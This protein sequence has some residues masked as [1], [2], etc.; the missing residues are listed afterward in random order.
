MTASGS[1]ES[2][3]LLRRRIVNRAAVALGIGLALL[4]GASA[5][6]YESSSEY[7]ASFDAIDGEAHL[8][9]ALDEVSQLVTDEV[10]GARGYVVSAD[11]VFLEGQIDAERRLPGALDALDEHLSAV[12]EARAAA[13]LRAAVD[14]RRAYTRATIELVRT[15]SLEQA[16]RRVAV[17]PGR[18]L[19]ARVRAIVEDI[20]TRRRLARDR[21]RVAASSARRR[22]AIAL[23][24]ALFV[25]LAL[26]GLA[27]ARVRSDLREL[28]RAALAL[29]QGESRFRAIAET[30]SDLIRIHARDL[31]TVYASPSS[32]PLLGY[33]Q[34]EM[35]ALRPEALVPDS[36]EAAKLVALVGESLARGEAPPTFSHEYRH[37]D[38]AI[39]LFET[40]VD[41]IRDA[42][43]KIRRFQSTGRDV[44]DRVIEETALRQRAEQ[45][46]RE[47][48]ELRTVSMRDELTGLFNRRGLA[49]LAQG[50]RLTAQASGAPIVVFFCDLDGLKVINDKLGHE[51]GDRAIV[52]AAAVV[53]GVARGSDV[54][55]RIGGDEL[56]VVGIVGLA[57]SADAFRARLES[58]IA[59]HNEREGRK[60]RL[61]M[62][63]GVATWRPDDARTLDAL[64]AEADASMYEQ[65]GWKR[66]STTTAGLSVIRE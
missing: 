57:A 63:V 42:D 32:L 52:D 49:Q 38:G 15:G 35:L 29:E 21:D 34:D 7:A 44:T 64:I 30:S 56:V 20:Q 39:R 24:S 53:R 17:G 3:R 26:G 59:T 13:R 51:E 50:L 45:L 61:S 37:K 36:G 11:E 33:T 48:D 65:K 18:A 9:A 46:G 28:E 27:V 2:R 1:L 25:A 5:A 60:Y 43:G 19:L 55:A 14:A 40:R 4:F 66:R 54:V 6:A 23:L 16:R 8:Q 22:T 62:S 12:G 41:P 31:S 47:A 10:A 58:R